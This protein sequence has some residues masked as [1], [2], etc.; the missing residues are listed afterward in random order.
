MNPAAPKSNLMATLVPVVS[1]ENKVVFSRPTFES[2]IEVT[3]DFEPRRTIASTCQLQFMNHMLEHVSC[4]GCFNIGLKVDLPRLKLTH[5]ITEDLGITIGQ[6]LLHLMANN[7]DRGINT[8]G[9]GSGVLDEALSRAV[10]S[11]EGRPGFWLRNHTGRELDELVEDMQARDL[12]AFLEGL[13]HGFKA[14]IHVDIQSGRN[15]H[16]IWESVFRALGEALREL[17]APCPWRAGTIGAI[18]RTLY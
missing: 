18:K 17:F 2:E 12:E 5:V 4:R 8:F 6:A 9:A 16:H 15:P 7:V 14:S 3:V 10:V 1:T 13:S 11:V